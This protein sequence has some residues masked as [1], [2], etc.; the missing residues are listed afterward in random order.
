MQERARTLRKPRGPCKARR[1]NRSPPRWRTRPHLPRAVIGFPPHQ[2]YRILQQ[3][4]IPEHG[5]ETAGERHWSA[6]QPCRLGDGDPSTAV[7]PPIDLTLTAYLHPPRSSST[8]PFALGNLATSTCP[9]GRWCHFGSA[10]R[11]ARPLQPPSKQLTG[12]PWASL[13]VQ[14]IPCAA[15]FYS[16]LLGV[17]S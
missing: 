3:I 7:Q 4:S 6:A 9:P 13:W 5:N 1:I 11:T 16:A 2:Y 14:L 10:A 15:D 8:P 12:G 17:V